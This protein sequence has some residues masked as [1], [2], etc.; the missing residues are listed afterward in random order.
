M[1][2][3]LRTFWFFAAAVGLDVLGS[4][5]RTNPVLPPQL[6]FDDLDGL[7][8]RVVSK[9]FEEDSSRQERDVERAWNS[10][11]RSVREGG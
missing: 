4:G 7:V 5:E 11:L 6:Y 1:R 10:G 2:K 8:A 9:V 3:A